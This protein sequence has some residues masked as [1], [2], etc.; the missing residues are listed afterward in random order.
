MKARWN[1]QSEQG[2]WPSTSPMKSTA[3]EAPSARSHARNSAVSPR[4]LSMRVD[5]RAEVLGD[6]RGGRA[7]AV[8]PDEAAIGIEEEHLARMAHRVSAGRGL[9]RDALVEDLERRGRGLD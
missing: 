3:S 6:L 4:R 2:V 9:V 5:P 8:E 1:Q 7:V